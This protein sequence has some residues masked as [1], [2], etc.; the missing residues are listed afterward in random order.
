[1]EEQTN[2]KGNKGIFSS[3]FNIFRGLKGGNE[4]KMSNGTCKGCGAT[5]VRIFDIKRGN[6]LCVKCYAKAKYY[7]R[8]AEGKKAKKVEATQSQDKQ[9]YSE[10]AFIEAS[11]AQIV[12][13][14]HCK[15]KLVLK[16]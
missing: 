1:M 15:K 9:I 7:K 6:D 3:R 8:K 5:D 16:N 13:C 10:S 4:T 14:P 11:G 2:N 12:I